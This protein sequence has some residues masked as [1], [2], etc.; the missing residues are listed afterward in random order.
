MHTLRELLAHR[1]LVWSLVQRPW[2]LPCLRR[3]RLTVAPPE[4]EA[5]QE[6]LRRAGGRGL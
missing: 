3:G 4:G 6:R 1:V 2:K 5:A